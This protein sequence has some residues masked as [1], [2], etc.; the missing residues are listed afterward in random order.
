MRP[1]DGPPGPA[2]AAPPPVPQLRDTRREV[3]HREEPLCVPDR[4]ACEAALGRHRGSW[5]EALAL[6]S[7][8]ETTE[9][10]VEGQRR[11]AR[12]NRE[13]GEDDYRYRFGV[14][15]HSEC[16]EVNGEERITCGEQ[17]E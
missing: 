14:M 15:H 10:C 6:Q 2:P 5:L 13:E 8:P 9:Q 3:G 16:V 1:R 7:E 11:P 4:P 12:G 17:E